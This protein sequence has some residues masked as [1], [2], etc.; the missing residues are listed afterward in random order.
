MNDQRKVIY[1]QRNDII[2]ATA[3]HE[4]A[5]EMLNDLCQKL[6][7]RFIPKGSYREEWNLTTLISEANRIFGTSL[8]EAYFAKKELDEEGLYNEI[9]LE[10]AK[11][12]Q[13]RE[14]QHGAAMMRNAERFIL[15]MTLDEVWKDHLHNLDHLR[16]GINLRAYGQKDPLNE[17]KREAFEMFQAMLEQLGEL[18]ISRICRLNIAGHATDEEINEQKRLRKQSQTFETRNDPAFAKYNAGKEAVAVLEPVKAYVAPEDRD[19]NDPSTWGKVA[20][21]EPCP[22]G[23]GKKYKHCHGKA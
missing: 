1:E 18:F 23:S 22:C 7:D 12:L 10:A 19:P 21:N 15:L 6:I 14:E 5:I 17:Y 8:T 4:A 2:A 11:V 16:Q 20:R 9:K 3:V 13:A